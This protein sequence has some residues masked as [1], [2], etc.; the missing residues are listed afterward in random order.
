TGEGS[1]ESAVSGT[2]RRRA[3]RTARYPGMR[4]LVL[5]GTRFL[6][7][8]IVDEAVSRG[9]DVTTFSRGLSGHSRPGA[10]AL[11]GDRT[12][13]ADL[14]PQ[15]VAASAQALAGHAGHYTYISSISA[16]AGFPS[17]PVT[18]DSP[19]VQGTLGAEG[20]DFGL[21][22]SLIKVGSEQAAAGAFPGRSL[23]VR[24]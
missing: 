19:V 2:R 18:E 12:N 15:H 10:E 14:G 23:I 11:R 17:Q 22:Y 6:G 9:Y 8:S 24:P 20:N 13:H 7:R 4:L 3:R 1:G 21:E 5:G 16:Y